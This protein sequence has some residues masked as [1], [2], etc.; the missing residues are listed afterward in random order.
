MS[1]PCTR[2][3]CGGEIHTDG[4]GTPVRCPALYEPNATICPL[5]QRTPHDAHEHE[6]LRCP[7]W[8][9]ADDDGT[10]PEQPPELPEL[11]QLRA[12]NESLR[13]QIQRAREALGTDERLACC[14]NCG[15]EAAIAELAQAIRL[16]REYVGEELLPPIDG[17]SWYDALRRHAPHELPAPE[18]QP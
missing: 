8:A 3:E 13:Y 10:R 15:H 7:G 4:W 16:T 17:W 18:E 11:D 6:G 2:P 14:L 1:G 12:D 9:P 5:V